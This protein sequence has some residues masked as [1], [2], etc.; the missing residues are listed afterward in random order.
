[1]IFHKRNHLLQDLKKVCIVTQTS[2]L[3]IIHNTNDKKGI[4]LEYIFG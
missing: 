1:M 3:G 2:N 4:F